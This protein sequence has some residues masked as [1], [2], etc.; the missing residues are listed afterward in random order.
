MDLRLKT[1]IKKTLV[2]GNTS[3]ISRTKE[4][5]VENKVQKN[6]SLKMSQTVDKVNSHFASLEIL[7][8][9]QNLSQLKS[10]T[11]VGSIRIRVQFRSTNNKRR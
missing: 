5:K 11:Q 7:S 4:V 6:P 3:L 8:I 9:R 10:T 1:K 2:E